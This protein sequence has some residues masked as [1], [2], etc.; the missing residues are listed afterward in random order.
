MCY[1][2]KYSF[3]VFLLFIAL[4]PAASFSQADSSAYFYNQ[5]NKATNEKAKLA[6]LTQFAWSIHYSDSAITYYLKAIEL[7]NKLNSHEYIAQNNNRLGVAYRY[8]G[9]YDKA[10]DAYRLAYAIA[11]SFKIPTEKGF[12]LCNIGNLYVAQNSFQKALPYY[13]EAEKIFIANKFPYGLGFCY[14]G[15]ANVYTK[16]KQYDKALKFANKS[17]TVRASINDTKNIYTSLYTQADIC[18]Q[19]NNKEEALLIYEDLYL[20]VKG[21]KN[22]REVDVCRQLALLNNELGNKQKSVEMALAAIDANVKAKSYTAIAPVYQQLAKWYQSNQNF[23]KA[24]YYQSLYLEA[25]D[26]IYNNEVAKT[27]SGFQLQ[28]KEKEIEVLE[29]TAKL[30]EQKA[31]YSKTITQILTVAVVGIFFTALFIAYN[32]RKQQ[33]A[34]KLIEQQRLELEKQAAELTEINQLKDRLFSI[35][36]HDL[37][38]PLASLKGVNDLLKMNELTQSDIENIGKQIDLQLDGVLNVLE[39][40]LQWSVAQIQ[41]GEQLNKVKLHPQSL[42]K[43]NFQ[44]LE[45]VA[46]EKQIQ[47]IN[48]IPENIFVLADANHLNIVLRN[49]ISNAIKFTNTKGEVKVM[50]EVEADNVLFK[51]L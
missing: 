1:C 28:Q 26:S 33:K 25:K 48:Q 50:A 47:L 37:R 16:L 13:F 7:A 21:K 5:I 14:V 39:N 10:M 42:V 17:V 34:A 12:A 35:I 3:V 22:I 20:E 9:S 29:K 24:W 23:E 15:I 19:M 36:S 18:W 30:N 43:N 31:A 46:N 4:L 49:L 51:V 38:R 2:R 45:R 41:S 11:D 8:I 27:L 6:Y 44:F 40:L 32:W